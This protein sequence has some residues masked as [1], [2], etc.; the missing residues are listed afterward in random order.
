MTTDTPPH[1]LR[2]PLHSVV[3][4]VG[5]LLGQN[6]E[7]LSNNGVRRY[8]YGR[9]ILADRGRAFENM[10]WMVGHESKG[11]RTLLVGSPELSEDSPSDDM[12]MIVVV[13]DSSVSR[14]DDVNSPLSVLLPGDRI[15]QVTV[16]HEGRHLA[17]EVVKMTPKAGA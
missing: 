10:R 3:M 14:T 9:A 12:V 4:G 16:P 7:G 15:Y 6:S 11:E 8:A 13:G 17:I 5:R 2:E 1:K